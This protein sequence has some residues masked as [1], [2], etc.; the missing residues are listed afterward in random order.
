M[1]RTIES[2]EDTTGKGHR[3]RVVGDG[4][5]LLA[6]VQLPSERDQAAEGVS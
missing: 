4:A 5:V 3:S 1:A 2:S 6:V